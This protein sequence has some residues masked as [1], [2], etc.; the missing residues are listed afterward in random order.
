MLKINK[1]FMP[2][3]ALGLLIIFAINQS[4]GASLAN[5]G[6]PSDE[7]KVK[8]QL[9]TRGIY[10]YFLSLPFVKLIYTTRINYPANELNKYNTSL[11]SYTNYYNETITNKESI[12][13]TISSYEELKHLFNNKNIITMELSGLS[14]I[15]PLIKD[16]KFSKLA[17]NVLD[18]IK[19][20]YF[21]NNY[22]SE[23]GDNPEDSLYALNHGLNP[24]NVSKMN[25]VLDTN[26]VELFN[27]NGYKT[28]MINFYNN[29]F[30]YINYVL[31]Y[32]YHNYHLYNE[33]TYLHQKY[34]F[35]QIDYKVLNTNVYNLYMNNWFDNIPS[36]ENNIL[37][38]DKQNIEDLSRL[39]K[40]Y[41]KNTINPINSL[42]YLKYF[43]KNNLVLQVK[44]TL[45]SLLIYQLILITVFMNMIKVLVLL[46]KDILVNI[47]KL[48]TSIPIGY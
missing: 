10:G 9:N 4:I 16:P 39:S 20:S 25:D 15:L 7:Q 12:L 2:L 27:N 14:P 28:S 48:T 38:S 5:I 45:I 22:F 33:N 1:T 18:F 6:A 13:G 46:I 19:E 36:Y 31:K 35:N 3:I 44:T 41:Y 29:K 26:L 24:Y 32:Q 42:E 23:T 34:N 21:L 37:E 17:P 30:S 40:Y 11:N 47:I 8:N 43:F